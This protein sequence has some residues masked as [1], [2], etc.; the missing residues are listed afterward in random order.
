[1]KQLQLA[2][3]TFF[4]GLVLILV[5]GCATDSVLPE[6]PEI[7]ISN[8]DIKDV[9][10][11]SQAFLFNLN[12]ANPNKFSLPLSGVE[13]DLKFSDV[14]VGSGSHKESVSL[15]AQGDT[16]IPIEVGTNLL[17]TME[18]FKSLL[19]TGKLNMDYKLSGKLLMVGES[20]GIPFTVNGNLLD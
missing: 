7:S 8:V 18:N 16:A 12:V 15:V 5:S 17:E 9:G 10:L 4:A 3:R 20:V 1:M 13:F 14:L 19:L 2:T 11:N 6:S